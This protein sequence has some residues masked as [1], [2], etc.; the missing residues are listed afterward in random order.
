MII[1]HRIKVF[2]SILKIYITSWRFCSDK[3]VRRCSE[4]GAE[5]TGSWEIAKKVNVG[6]GGGM[7]PITATAWAWASTTLSIA[8]WQGRIRNWHDMKLSKIRPCDRSK[9]PTGFI[10]KECKSHSRLLLKFRN[11]VVGNRFPA[12]FIY[13]PTLCHL[14]FITSFWF[15]ARRFL[16]NNCFS[17]S[18]S[19]NFKRFKE[20]P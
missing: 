16:N 18:Q 2:L 5:T 14:S 17:I 12:Y 15:I 20:K 9:R 19:T 6:G 3:V 1:R 4:Q 8:N 10:I 11:C 7:Q 13:E